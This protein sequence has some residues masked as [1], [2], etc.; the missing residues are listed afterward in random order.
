MDPSVRKLMKKNQKELIAEKNLVNT[1]LSESIR[2]DEDTENW[3]TNIAKGLNVNDIMNIIDI[4][5]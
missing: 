2:E 4:T 5:T 1:L 3:R